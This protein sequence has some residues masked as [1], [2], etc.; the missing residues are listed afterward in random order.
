MTSSFTTKFGRTSFNNADGVLFTNI[1]LTNVGQI[2]VAGRI[3]AVL[4]SVSEEQ[5][6]LI[7]PDGRLA[8]GKFYLDVSPERGS[9]SPG[10]S[11]RSRDFQLLNRDSIKFDFSIRLLA[12]LNNAPTSFVTQPPTITEAGSKLV[13]TAEAIDPDDGQVLTY[14]I[15][16]GPENASINGATGEL[17]WTP[18]LADLGRQSLTIRATDPF[19]QF[20]EQRFNIEVVEDLRNRP[21]I[22]TTNPVTTAT[23]SS[24]F[25]I[26]TLATGDSPAG[27][28]VVDGFQGPRIVTANE[29]DQTIGVYAGQNND[30]FDDVSTVSTGFPI[31]G[32]EIFDVGY[33]V[34]VGFPEIINSFSPKQ[35]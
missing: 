2:P 11:A 6:A 14:S 7:D 17:D 18:S 28:S 25:E 33:T 30:R 32:N 8:D 3:I 4:D 21:P 26:T 35:E 29:G 23:A 16:S 1:Q 19:G 22:F 24:G 13:Y 34:D 9:I 12:E 10:Q 20:V 31:P 27:V 15:V 5:I